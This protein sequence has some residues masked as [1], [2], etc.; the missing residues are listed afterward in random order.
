[1]GFLPGPNSYFM[2][3]LE[4]HDEDRAIYL[5]GRQGIDPD[6]IA[7]QRTM[8]YSTS[9]LL[10]VGM[11]EVYSGQEVGWGLGISDYDQR[12]RGV[13]TWNTPSASILMP[14]YQKLAQIRKQ[15]PAFTTQQMVRVTSDFAGVYA[16]TRPYSGQNGLVVA[17]L[18]GIP[19]TVTVTL[20]TSTTP[21]S[22][23]GVSDGIPYYASDLYNSTW[24]MITFSGGTANLTVNLPAYG[25]AV[26][27]VDVV[28]RTVTLPPLTGIGLTDPTRP[29]ELALGQN[30]PNPFNPTTSIQFEISEVAH[31]RLKVFDVL[32]REVETLVDQQM[33]PGAFT[34]AW[35]GRNSNGTSV[36][37]GVYFY[38]LQ[39]GGQ[40]ISKRMLLLR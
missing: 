33:N 8:A 12:R 20:A 31:A 11:P 25:M 5:F 26:Y 10:A 9:V 4:N 14:H 21:P 3:F 27:V 32:G 15:F 35:D 38:S 34:V 13:I 18:E 40:T 19:H 29:K 16:Y 6:S 17:N 36:G 39:A 28:Q 1:M 24:S 23:E 37:S 22:V 7:R 30:Y 2:R